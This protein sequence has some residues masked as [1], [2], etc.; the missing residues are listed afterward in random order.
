M[1]G[2]IVMCMDTLQKV[3]LNKK[4]SAQAIS[5]SQRSLEYLIA[6]GLVQTRRVGRRVLIP[7]SALEKFARQDHPEPLSFRRNE[8]LLSHE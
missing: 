7:R 4:E 8:K 5:I 6:Q 2:L 1:H 3:L